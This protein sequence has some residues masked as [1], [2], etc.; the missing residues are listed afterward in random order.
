[1]WSGKM[2]IQTGFSLV[3]LAVVMVI[4]GL[5]IGGLLTPMS[6]QQEMSKTNEAK[7]QLEDIRDALMGYAAINGRLPCP[8]THLTN[9]AES[10]GGAAN[11][12][13][14]HGFIPATTLS[15]NG[16]RN[17]QGLLLDPWNN[18]YRYSISNTDANANGAWDFV[19][20]GEMKIVTIANLIPNLIVC[21]GASASGVNC[22][23]SATLTTNAVAVIFS[24]GKDWSSYVSP[25]EQENAGEGTG[26]VLGVIYPIATDRVF[27]SKTRSSITGAEFDDIVL[28]ISPNILY[29]QMLKTGQL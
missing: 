7:I 20:T 16:A 21:D 3:E 22:G 6:A 8:A 4:I 2:R 27:A 13:V 9:G 17:A 18:P 24:Q 5:L 28:W 15:L 10:G 19:R 12:G 14:Q 11:C 1:M 26:A 25:A 23:A 29:T